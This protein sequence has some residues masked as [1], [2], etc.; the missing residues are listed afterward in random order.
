MDTNGKELKGESDVFRI[1]GWGLRRYAWLIVLSV[2]AL[3]F[4]VPAQLAQTPE[5]YDAQAQVG[6][7]EPL[8]LPNLDPLPRLGETVFTNGAVADAVR[9]AFVPPLP[10]SAAVIPDRVELVAAQDNIVFT[11]IGHGPTPAAAQQAANTAA[12]TLTAEL[13]KYTRPVGAFA[14]Q[15]LATTPT[16]PVPTIGGPIALALGILAGLLAGVGLVVTV[17]AWRRPVVDAGGA[18]AATGAPVFARVR[19]A[20]SSNRIRGLPQLSHRLRSRPVEV[21]YLT[22]AHATARARRRLAAELTDILGRTRSVTAVT[23]D[24][25]RAAVIEGPQD[26]LLESSDASLLIVDGPS[27]RDMATRPLRSI[28][29]LVVREGVGYASLRKQAESYLDGGPSGIVLVS[30]SAW[31]PRNW[32]PGR[33]RPKRPP[34][35]QPPSSPAPHL[36]PSKS[37]TPEQV[38]SER[39][40]EAARTARPGPALDGLV[41]G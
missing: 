34:R 33:R 28:A 27:Q 22:G 16:E 4:L 35:E 31:D 13:N 40:T 14:I 25:P 15:R 8:N 17:L 9:N 7:T 2:L 24:D 32:W 10:P 19:L 1:L 5:S 6:P 3:G 38:G 23:G 18:E 36:K 20:H 21:L 41:Q 37:R 30:R 29:L 12:V 11:V 26:Q 39:D